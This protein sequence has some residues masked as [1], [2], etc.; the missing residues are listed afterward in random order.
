MGM[1]RSS[2]ARRARILE[3]A[4]GELRTRGYA[5]TSMLA[6]ATAAGASK[7]TLYRLFGDKAGLFAALVGHNA[8]AI[9]AEVAGVLGDDLATDEVLRRFASGLLRLLLGDRAVTI[10]RVAIAEAATSAE[11]G[12]ILAR[13]GRE[14]TGPLILRYLE[15]QRA[16]GRLE[17]PSAEEAFE[18]FLGLLLRDRQVRVLLGVAP[19]LS[20]EEVD[21]LAA[22]SVAYFMRL[23]GTPSTGDVSAPA[24]PEVPRGMNLTGN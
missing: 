2:D 7:E 22:R 4:L 8:A 13:A 24:L 9:N 3:A 11:L 23:F 21:S 1:A 15:A 10:N 6:I 5:G 19:G 12:R 20:D 18:V 14:T 17:F 16:H